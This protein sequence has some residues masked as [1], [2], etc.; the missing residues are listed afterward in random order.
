MLLD[1]II[2]RLL[3]YEYQK[4]YKITDTKSSNLETANLPYLLKEQ[5]IVML[6]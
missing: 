1:D 2:K 5:E 6:I 4:G 3:K